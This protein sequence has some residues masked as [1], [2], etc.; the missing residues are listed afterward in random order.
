METCR[1]YL[2]EMAE[3]NSA[4]NFGAP[5]FFFLALSLFRTILYALLLPVLRREISGMS[6]FLCYASSRA[7]ETGKP[8]AASF[9]LDHPKKGQDG[10]RVLFPHENGRGLHQV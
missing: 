5:T 3:N 4:T 10:S 7:G 9:V 8:T 6:T 1:K 2:L